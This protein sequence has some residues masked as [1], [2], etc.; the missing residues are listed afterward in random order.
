M[1]FNQTIKEAMAKVKP[2]KLPL[3]FPLHGKQDG[4]IGVDLDGT[5]AYHGSWKGIEHIGEPIPSMIEK[6]KFALHIGY[7]VKIFTARVDEGEAALPFINDWVK[8]HIG[9]ELPI[10]NVKDMNCIQIWDD[11]AIGVERNT[12]KFIGIYD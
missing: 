3:P 12:G 4:W 1:T 10:T 7:N 11:R 5:L 6:V 9:V 8:K 2:V